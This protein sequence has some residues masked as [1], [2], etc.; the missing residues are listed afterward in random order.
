MPVAPPCRHS[1]CAECLKS[2]V[3]AA[4]NRQP[5][6]GARPGPVRPACPLCRET[7]SPET[8]SPNSMVFQDMLGAK[9]ACGNG[10]CTAQFCPLRWKHH[11]EE[12]PA[13]VVQCAHQT[14]GCT[15]KCARRDLPGHLECCSYEKIK[16]LIP[17]VSASLKQ[18]HTQ[19]HQL[20]ARVMAQNAAMANT[21]AF[22]MSMH[23]RE[24]PGAL[25]P[26]MYALLWRPRDWRRY[27]CPNPGD[28]LSKSAL[29][30]LA[31]VAFLALWGSGMFGG[32]SGLSEE[33]RVVCL[34]AVATLAFLTFLEY[35]NSS[36]WH[37]LQHPRLLKGLRVGPT[38]VEG[39][40]MLV[41]YCAI[42]GLP[43]WDRLPALALLV[44]PL[45][46]PTVMQ[47][48]HRFQVKLKNAQIQGQIAQAQ[49]PVPP[50]EQRKPSPVKLRGV[51][52]NGV[53]RAA[54]MLVF[55]HEAVLAGMVLAKLGIC[56][57]SPV[58]G[59]E[60]VNASFE[61]IWVTMSSGLSAED[62]EHLH[63]LH[64]RKFRT[65]KAPFQ[66]VTDRRTRGA[67][68]AACL[69]MF[70]ITASAF[71]DS[72]DKIGCGLIFL[73]LLDSAHI[74][75][76]V[77]VGRWVMA[78]LVQTSNLLNNG[79]DRARNPA[80]DLLRSRALLLWVSLGSVFF[81]LIVVRS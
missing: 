41:V 77:Q 72:V 3:R 64:Q 67:I 71:R 17:R 16:G 59:A 6:N 63:Q 46:Y 68:A 62:K 52:V 18:I 25:F 47:G 60:A 56:I 26:A 8:V 14:A 34:A 37:E 48:F 19:V 15:W 54:A 12:C 69:S 49:H 73:W 70:C 44:A 4:A 74:C 28:V 76:E 42:S 24:T 7:F 31:P 57:A 11:Q 21:R 75:W 32:G 80:R 33:Q 39:A 55:G 20:E 45:A 51:V 10:D 22:V 79:P 43:P 29:I 61:R 23:Q 30:C 65:M 50:R 9:V 36:P 35:D 78:S 5:R 13:A 58:L 40:S 38:L 81:V 1:F 27:S 53:N 2:V 66:N